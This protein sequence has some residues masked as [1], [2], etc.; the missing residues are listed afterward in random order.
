MTSGSGLTTFIDIHEVA[1]ILNVGSIRHARRMV[2]HLTPMK[3]GGRGKFK[4][5]RTEVEKLKGS[6][7]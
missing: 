7:K 5:T 4:W 3:I 1:L 6:L 2:K